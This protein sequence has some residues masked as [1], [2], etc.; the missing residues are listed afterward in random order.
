M[1]LPGELRTVHPLLLPAYAQLGIECCPR[2]FKTARRHRCQ[3]EWRESSPLLMEVCMQA[4]MQLEPNMAPEVK[5]ERRWHFAKRLG[6][7][8]TFAY[9]ASYIIPFPFGYLPFTDSVVQKYTDFWHAIV[10]SRDFSSPMA[11]RRL[12]DYSGHSLAAAGLRYDFAGKEAE[13]LHQTR[14]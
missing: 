11:T 8:F 3:S 4:Q 9:F 1:A 10:P 13:K 6:F 5:L 12:W 14:S 2:F 7:R